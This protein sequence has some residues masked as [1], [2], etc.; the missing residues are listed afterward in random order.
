M[1]GCNSIALPALGVGNLK[2]PR[3]DTACAMFDAVEEF[4]KEALKPKLKQVKLVVYDKDWETCEVCTCSSP[5]GTI[6]L[7]PVL[8]YVSLHSVCLSVYP[9]VRLTFVRSISHRMLKVLH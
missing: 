1:D 3:R 9:P 2:Y 7:H 6:G 5:C 4:R 8:L